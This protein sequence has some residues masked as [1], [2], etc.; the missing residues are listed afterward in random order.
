MSVDPP[1]PTRVVRSRDQ[2]EKLYAIT[3]GDLDE[4][5]EW[6]GSAGWPAALTKAFMRH[7]DADL[8]VQA[9]TEEGVSAK[10]RYP[11]YAGFAAV[12]KLVSEYKLRKV[13]DVKELHVS[14]R[15]VHELSSLS[16][17]EL[18]L[19]AEGEWEPQLPPAA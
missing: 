4:L 9:W 3:D 1:K 5:R 18:E 13:A 6:I 14:G 16:D 17:R 2:I 15:V 12:A 10:V 7:L 11:N 8:V 19:I